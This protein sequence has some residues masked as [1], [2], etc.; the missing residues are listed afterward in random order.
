M[1]ADYI[2]ENADVCGMFV[3][4]LFLTIQVEPLKNLFMT[5]PK[6]YARHTKC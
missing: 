3:K 1:P 6:R 4:D 5:I 2:T